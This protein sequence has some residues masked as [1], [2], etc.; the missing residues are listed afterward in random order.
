MGP[1]G[2]P[3]PDTK[4]HIVMFNALRK[5]RSRRSVTLLTTV[6]TAALLTTAAPAFADGGS[7]D[8]SG[9]GAS[10]GYTGTPGNGSGTYKCG[11]QI[12]K[13]AGALYHLVNGRW[14]R[15]QASQY[16]NC[17]P[18]YG[19][20]GYSATGAVMLCPVGYEVYRFYGSGKTLAVTRSRLNLPDWC[21]AESKYTFAGQTAWDANPAVTPGLPE[22]VLKSPSP[23]Q[24]INEVPAEVVR[25]E[26]GTL[27]TGVPTKVDGSCTAVSKA[28]PL[29]AWLKTASAADQVSYRIA[30]GNVYWTMSQKNKYPRTAAQELGLKSITGGYK[31]STR[32]ADPTKAPKADAKGSN[33]YATTLDFLKAPCAS[34]FNFAT[35]IDD[36]TNKPVGSQSVAGTCY[37]PLMR[38]ARQMGRGSSIAYTFPELAANG[39]ERYSTYY[40]SKTAANPTGSLA[41]HATW[42]NA[43]KADYLKRYGQTS[44]GTGTDGKQ[45]IPLNHYTGE[46]TASNIGKKQTVSSAKA[47]NDLRSFARCRETTKV[48]LSVPKS[49][50]AP[51]KAGLQVSVQNRNVLQAGGKAYQATFTA[52]GGQSRLICGDGKPC[53][54]SRAVLKSLSY[55]MALTGTGSYKE[56]AAGQVSGCD[57]RVIKRVAGS[58]TT[59]GVLVAEFYNGTKPNQSVKLSVSNLKGTYAYTDTSSGL[60]ITGVNPVTGLPYT[61][62]TGTVTSTHTVN[63]TPTLAGTPKAMAFAGGVY[64]ALWPVMN[65]VDIPVG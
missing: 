10:N 52:T 57:F 19:D 36:V 33:Y 3:E 15:E 30:L 50:V 55:T 40:A 14:V 65:A 12:G 43:M 5:R 1:D 58:A 61:A 32:N 49:P 35:V 27:T 17:H 16:P 62:G 46:D 31:Y 28:N 2:A 20:M 41:D 63:F 6:L 42:R 51:Q 47:A 4:V 8:D 53:G 18:K 48:T 23:R 11:Q 54:T 60:Q 37:I 29:E 13:T 25:R 59:N 21:A 45:L 7:W 34:P 56:C 39:G 24:T 64:S 22:Y 38:T 9:P 44:D 26:T